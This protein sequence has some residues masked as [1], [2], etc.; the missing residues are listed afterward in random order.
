[1]NKL[2]S[3]NDDEKYM[4]YKKFKSVYDFITLRGLKGED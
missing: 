1:M 4:D 2:S 3:L